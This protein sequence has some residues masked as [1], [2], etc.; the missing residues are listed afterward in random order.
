MRP[1][2]NIMKFDAPP[3]C[4]REVLRYASCKEADEATVDII[5]ECIEE[6]LPLLSYKVCYA[7]LD[8][9]ISSDE[10]DFGVFRLGSKDLAKNLSGCDRVLLF[11]ATVGLE[12]DRLIEKQSRLSP[13]R[14]LFL[15]ALGAERIEALCDEFCKSFEKEN[16]V[17]LVPRFSAGYGDL[18]IETQKDVFR[19]LNPQKNIG[20]FLNESLLMSP[21]KS[22]TAFVGITDKKTSEHTGKC[23]KCKNKECSFRRI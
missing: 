10:C 1:M 3:L 6:A 21:S 2:I 18:S 13:S 16:G 19:V 15:Q 4:E 20:L 17:S 11:A 12:L 14:A 5:K 7:V 22:V 8:L 23:E 9:K